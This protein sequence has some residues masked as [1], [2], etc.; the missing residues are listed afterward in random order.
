MCARS[1][2]ASVS[3][4]KGLTNRSLPISSGLRV[5]EHRLESF[6]CQIS[7]IDDHGGDFLRVANVFEWIRLE[8]HQ[9]RPLSFLDGAE[10]IRQ[11]KILRRIEGCRLQSC[12]WAQTGVY[13]QSHFVMQ[14]EP[15]KAERVH[16]IG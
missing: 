4:L 5:G 15:G 11:S 3:A 8:Q 6:F 2:R 13:Q 16:R 12:Q 14:A 7:P 10:L 1:P 9:I